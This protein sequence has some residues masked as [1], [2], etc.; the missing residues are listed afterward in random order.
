Q[1]LVSDTWTQITSA[2]A[3]PRTVFADRQNRIWVAKYGSLKLSTDGGAT[4]NNAPS[5]IPSLAEVIAMCDDVF[6]NIY[7]ITGSFFDQTGEA[8]Y[9]SIG[10]TQSFT[11][12]DD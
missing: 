2:P 11:K 5:G 1:P 8:V 12:I 6:G 9:R 10:G 4:W 7:A 3:N